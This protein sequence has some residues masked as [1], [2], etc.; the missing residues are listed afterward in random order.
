MDP[1]PTVE[2]RLRSYLSCQAQIGAAALAAS[3]DEAF[4]ATALDALATT[5]R[6]RAVGLFAPRPAGLELVDGT[7]WLPHIQARQ[8]PAPAEL[9]PTARP[10]RSVPELR[11]ARL[12]RAHDL[13]DGLA[14][15]VRLPR[16][17]T[18]VLGV[19]APEHLDDDA[20]AQL[21]T[22]VGEL[23]G[24]GLR[25]R[26][27]VDLVAANGR[28]LAEAQELAHL[29]SYDWDIRTDTNVW[30]EELYRIYGAE[31]GDFQPTYD[32]FLARIHPDDRDK[33]MAVH[34]E[35]FETLE[36]YQMEERIV[37]PDG[38]VRILAT[39]GEVV[40]DD[41]GTPIRMRGIC[42][43]VTDRRMAERQRQATERAEE[44]RR[45][46]FRINDDVVQGLTSV[47]WA[48]DE[49][50]TDAARVAAAHT[51][52][53]ARS[54]IEGLLD[55]EDGDDIGAELTRSGAA[56]SPL[57]TDG[58]PMD[59]VPAL[60]AGAIAVGASETAPDA[61]RIVVA[62]DSADLRLL[63]TVQLALHRHCDLVGEA[64]TGLEAIDVVAHTQADVVL[65]DLAM[66][67]MSGLDAI[68]EIRR[69]SPHTRI[70]V[71]SG[72]SRGHLGDR[73]L[74]AGADAYVEKGPVNRIF[75]AL[76][77][78]FPQLQPG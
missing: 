50:R 43:D 61:I 70:I 21:V 53:A 65:L 3:S 74:E 77:Q 66:P 30:S 1:D 28:R 27:L 41:A 10:V 72:F 56:A 64:A 16:D 5:T 17:E 54:M 12:L 6:A 42:L 52:E 35:A 29:G 33:V 4:L 40:V 63:L 46:A 68:P 22:A 57:V 47:L 60:G 69:V 34:R 59:D 7:G 44:R 19:F 2:P 24:A 9:G 20:L 36:P 71:L 75:E 23:L 49:E 58:S 38:S 18:G 25:Q 55:G 8:L 31:P 73:A 62:D 11:D 48:L 15:E 37:R 51:L 67:G 14:C 76:H 45:H 32:E 39:T 26:E 13:S 78:A